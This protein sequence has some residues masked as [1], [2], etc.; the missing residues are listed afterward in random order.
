MKWSEIRRQYPN[1]FILVGDIIEEKISETKSK[2]LEGNV[3]KVTEDGREIRKVY[4]Q[5]KK[6]GVNVLY[7][8]PTTPE[9]FII[10]DVPFKG[11]VI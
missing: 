4:Q 11:I 6:R 3:L 2:I 9:E 5:Y 8:L 1:K 7:S 10:E